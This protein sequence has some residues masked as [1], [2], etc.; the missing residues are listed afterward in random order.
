MTDGS[1]A[2]G[3]RDQ[4]I[5]LI[6]LG[7]VLLGQGLMAWPV[8]GGSAGLTDDVPVLSGRHPLHLY[9]GSLG[10][11]TFM[12]RSATACFDPAF[13]AGYPK[14]PVFDGG[15]RPAEFFLC[16]LA[17][18]KFDPAAYKCGLFF[19]CLLAPVAFAVAARGAGICRAGAIVAAVLGCGV[20]W[21]PPA[22]LR[23]DAGEIDLLLAGLSVVVFIGWLARYHWEPGITSWCVLTVVSIVGWY[24]HPVVWLGLL[25]LFLVY[26]IALAPRHDLGW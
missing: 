10:A 17:Q 18:G 5:W 24:A 3:F 2:R 26:Y 11:A 22:R 8:F 7:L 25:P 21:S 20:W 23:F 12:S 13:Q 16:L 6:A 19:C 4:P 15:C 1:C 9:H 14:T